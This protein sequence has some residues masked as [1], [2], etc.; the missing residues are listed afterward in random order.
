VVYIKIFFTTPAIL[1][2]GWAERSEA[3]RCHRQMMGFAALSPSYRVVTGRLADS[4]LL[5]PPRSG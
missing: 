2:V 4:Q 1:D 3:H 5:S